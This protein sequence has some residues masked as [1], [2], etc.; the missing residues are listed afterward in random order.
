MYHLPYKKSKRALD[1]IQD[2]LFY[3][4]DISE[5]CQAISEQTG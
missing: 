5:N 1:L 3:T 4:F 2:W